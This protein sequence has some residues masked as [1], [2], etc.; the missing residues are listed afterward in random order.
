VTTDDE[1]VPRDGVERRPWW[2]S[3]DDAASAVDPEPAEPEDDGPPP[4]SGLD[5]TMLMMGAA[6]MVDWATERVMAPHAEHE[7]P[8]EHPQCVLC[9]TI[10][11]VGDREGLGLPVPQEG[12]GEAPRGEPARPAAIRW[13]PI[14]DGPTAP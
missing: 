2:Y 9:R 13:I 1:G 3:G 7:D 14:L 8:A 12:A 10:L 6:K 5:W 11:L 4:T